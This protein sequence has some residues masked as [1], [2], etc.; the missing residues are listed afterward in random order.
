MNYMDEQILSLRNMVIDQA[1]PDNDQAK[2]A[3]LPL[4]ESEQDNPVAEKNMVLRIGNEHITLEPR[5]I[6]DGHIEVSVPKSFSLMPLEKAK[7]KYPSEHRPQ[8]IYT[9]LEETI[10]ITLSPAD[11]LLDADE[12]PEFTEQMA[13]VLRSVQPIRNWKGTEQV[14]N[15]SGLSIGIIRFVAAGVDEN[16][17]NEMLLFIHEGHVMMGTFNCM[18]SSMQTWLPVAEHL[19]QSLRILPL[20]SPSPLKKEVAS[21]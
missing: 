3:P 1:T 17:Y 14:T 6:L 7:F 9:S 8:V 16:L 12:L 5:T 21:L 15:R 18:E 20:L 4:S 11:T 10:N 13:D 2:L 19:V